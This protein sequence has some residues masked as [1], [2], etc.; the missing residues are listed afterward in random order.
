M[1]YYCIYISIYL[2]FYFYVCLLPDNNVYADDLLAQIVIYQ[3]SILRATRAKGIKGA[4]Y[5]FASAPKTV[6]EMQHQLAACHSYLLDSMMVN[7]ITYR[8]LLLLTTIII[9]III[10]I[11]RNS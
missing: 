9:I 1:S 5:I 4:K 8:T 10:I 7:R 3:G 2:F 6:K 11:I